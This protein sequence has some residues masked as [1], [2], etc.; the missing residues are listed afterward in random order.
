[1]I[2]YIEKTTSIIDKIKAIDTKQS[3]KLKPLI[4]ELA[5]HFKAGIELKRPEIII[6]LQGILAKD[7]LKPRGKDEITPKL[8]S[9]LINKIKT[10]HFPSVSQNW[11]LRVLPDEYKEIRPK[12]QTIHKLKSEDLS[13][14]DLFRLQDEIMYRIRTMNSVGQPSKEIKLKEKVSDLERYNWKC[15]S[16]QEYAKIAIKMEKE[17]ELRHEEK[18][19]NKAS[20]SIRMARDER[21]ATTESQYQA[22]IVGAEFSRSL[23][24]VTE[25]VVEYIGRWDIDDNEKHCRECLDMDDC[26]SKKCKHL[27]H[28]TKKQLTTKGIKWAIE[29]NPALTELTGRLKGLEADQ[30]DMCAYMKI[31]FKNPKMK[32]NMADKKTLMARHIDKDDC[33]QCLGFTMEHKDFFSMKI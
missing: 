27:C 14:A 18:F 13:D 32:L 26:R 1:M 19:C 30:D 15:H 7:S 28:L 20:N 8:I 11:I 12:Q 33:D 3:I 25:E 21:Y 16:A 31:I 22:I 6:Q 10:Q 5:D 23:S 24:K 17:H 29:H 4:L 2:E 9:Q